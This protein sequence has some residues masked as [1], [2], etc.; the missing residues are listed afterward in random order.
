MMIR[1]RPFLVSGVLL[2]V[3]A[4]ALSACNQYDDSDSNSFGV[5]EKVAGVNVDSGGGDIEV[6]AGNGDAVKVTENR[7]YADGKRPATEHYVK[8]GELHLK[9]DS[10]CGSGLGSADCTVNYRVEVPRGV[11]VSLHSGGGSVHLDGVSGGVDVGTGGGEVK[12]KDMA[13]QSLK[14]TSGGGSIDVAWSQAPDDV[15]VNAKGGNV[16]LHV[17]DSGYQVSASTTL[18]SKK[19]EVKTD[20]SSER[21]IKARTFAGDVK[22]LVAG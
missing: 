19:V 18:G 17:P 6:A 22:V 12:A 14:A 3:M 16:T 13:A 7:K 20:S 21:R 15:D 4:P 9:V 5:K 8:D 1:F 2:L 11:A 10:D